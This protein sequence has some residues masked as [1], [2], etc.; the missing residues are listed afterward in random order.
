[1]KAMILD[2][3]TAVWE[4]ETSLGPGLGEKDV[5]LPLVK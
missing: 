1:M 2:K 4:T 3:Y 5:V